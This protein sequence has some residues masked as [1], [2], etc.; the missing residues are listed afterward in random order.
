MRG[1]R[2]TPNTG[3]FFFFFAVLFLYR[4]EMRTEANQIIT[5]GPKTGSEISGEAQLADRS[6]RHKWREDGTGANLKSGQCFVL[7]TS[8]RVV[9]V[10]TFS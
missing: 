8:V 1:L 2:C 4:R 7:F 9:C 5:I 10:Q 3:I 6:K